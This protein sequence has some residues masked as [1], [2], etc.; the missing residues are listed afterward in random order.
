MNNNIQKMNQ[1]KNI[2]QMIIECTEKCEPFMP[3]MIP[4]TD[5]EHF[6]EVAVNRI[7]ELLDIAKSVI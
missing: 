1:L 7:A 5:E 2:A 3:W 6:A 4:V